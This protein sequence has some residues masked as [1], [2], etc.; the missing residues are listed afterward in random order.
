VISASGGSLLYTAVVRT[1]D[2]TLVVIGEYG[3]NLQDW[4]PLPLNPAGVPAV[5]QTGVPA[6]TQRRVFTLPGGDPTQF[7]RLSITTP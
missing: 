1:N 6:G 7:L 3:G 2:P 4:L 5:D